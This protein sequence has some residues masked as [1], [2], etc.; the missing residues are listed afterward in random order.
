MNRYRLGAIGVTTTFFV[1]VTVTVLLPIVVFN[2]AP[3]GR[4]NTYFPGHMGNAVRGR[5]IYVREG[6]MYCH[7]MYT[8]LQ[9]R[10]MGA[11]T[12]AGDFNGETPNQLGTART[13]PDLSNEGLRYSDGWHRAHLV[14]ARTVK[15]GSIMPSFAFLSNRDL[16]DLIAFIQSLGA[17]RKLTDPYTPP[18]EFNRALKLKTVDLDSSR[19]IQVGHGL[20]RQECSACHGKEGRGNGPAS[21]VMTTKPA[22]FSQGKYNNF[23]DLYWFYRISE[24]SPASGMPRWMEALSAD[25]RWYLVAYLKTLRDPKAQAPPMEKA[26]AYPVE[27]RHTHQHWEPNI[28]DE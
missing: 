10:G 5:Q 16:T 9:D 15:P 22:D 24:G 3:S 18:E 25:Q 17:N 28:S 26:G 7:S 20:Y 12:V 4:Q 1:S 27:M 14:N 19:S 21:W 13:G 23:S 8:R 2:P 6:C 11:L